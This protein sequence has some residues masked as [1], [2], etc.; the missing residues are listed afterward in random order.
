MTRTSKSR[1]LVYANT[2]YEPLEAFYKDPQWREITDWKSEL[3]PY[4]DQAKRM[5]GVTDNPRMTPSD[6]VMKQVAD[7]LG[8]GDTFRLTPVGVFFGGPGQEPT[9]T[10]ADPFC[11]RGT[12]LWVAARLGRIAWASDRDPDAV[13]RTQSRVA[14]ERAI[15]NHVDG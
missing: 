2:L 10:V 6:H 9:D 7:E 15:F 1:S 11:G 5:L 4:Y 12:T 13:S 3:A 14:Q 8:V